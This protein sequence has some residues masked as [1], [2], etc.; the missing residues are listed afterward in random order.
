MAMAL[1]WLPLLYSTAAAQEPAAQAGPEP[2]KPVTTP[3]SKPA[4]PATA[5][6]EEAEPSL[7]YLKDKQ[8]NLQAV[9]N[10]NFEDFEELYRLKHQLVQGDERPRYSI[11]QISAA[12]TV[13][14]EHG[15]QAS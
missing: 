9:P 10:F 8:G 12:A 13:A 6:V 11:Q 3:A 4:G 2:G 14:G 15:N 7:Y 1:C 5:R